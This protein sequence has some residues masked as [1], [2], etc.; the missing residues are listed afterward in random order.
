MNRL[1]KFLIDEEG[2]SLAE[3]GIILG[4]IVTVGATVIATLSTRITGVI[5]NAS[6]AIPS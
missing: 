5:S 3:Y 4:V 6:T 2:I 1:Q